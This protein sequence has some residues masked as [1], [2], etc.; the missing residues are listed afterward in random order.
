MNEA[1]LVAALESGQISGIGFDVLTAEPP[2]PDN[3]LLAV[4]DRPNVIVTPHVAWAS[5]QAQA[6]CWRQAVWNIE[7]FVAGAPS[8]VV[9]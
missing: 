3:P 5:H 4:L 1:D 9:G 7:N 8:H 6:E 2:A